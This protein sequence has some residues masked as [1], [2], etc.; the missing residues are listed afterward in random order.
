M[1]LGVASYQMV[2]YLQRSHL[3]CFLQR[4]SEAMVY[5]DEVYIICLITATHTVA[6]SRC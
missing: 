2:M 4:S 6:L 3:K 1:N 5:V